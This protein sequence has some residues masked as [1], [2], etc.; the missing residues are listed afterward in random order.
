MNSMPWTEVAL[1]PTADLAS[2]LAVLDRTALQIVVVVDPEGVLLGT[3]TDGDIRRA[4]LRGGAL[5]DRL[6]R[7]MNKFPRTVA[8]GTDAL[9]ALAILR[10]LVIRCLPVLDERGRVV[11]LIL[12]EELLGPPRRDTPVLVMAGGRGERLRPLTDVL[13]KPLV[14]VAGEPLID[15]LLRRL[16]AQGFHDIWVSVHYKASDITEHLGDGSHFGV[17]IRYVYEEEPLGTAGAVRLVT[18]V[19]EA[20][21]IL[22]CNA[23]TVHAA[24]YGALLDHHVA[25]GAAA[26]MAVYGHQIEIPY[27]VVQA[28][29]GYVTSLVEKPVRT[30][31]VSAGINVVSRA[32]VTAAANEGRVDMPEVIEC[33]LRDGRPVAV[34]EVQGYWL[35]IGTAG[36]LAKANSDHASL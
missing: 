8:E 17:T 20:E 10:R 34:H 5:T 9:E 16:S 25:T 11:D 27:G 7:H 35:D 3:V 1:G 6:W 15:I 29:D 18:D 36:T 4:L 19:D 26:T 21:P 28:V 13:P 33:A 32:L 31:L 2:A 24:D 12:L 22:V 30:E 23:D 14:R